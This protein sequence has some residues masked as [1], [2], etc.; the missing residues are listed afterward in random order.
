[1][2]TGKLS[3]G[4]A[5]GLSVIAAFSLTML[6]AC[7]TEGPAD[8][9]RDG[10]RALMSLDGTEGRSYLNLDDSE[11]S[12]YLK[13]SVADAKDGRW[14]NPGLSTSLAAIGGTADGR[15]LRIVSASANGVSLVQKGES[16]NILVQ[17]APSQQI[18]PGNNANWNVVM[19][20]DVQFNGGI[21]VPILPRILNLGEYTAHNKQ[22]GLNIQWQPGDDPGAEVTVTITVDPVLTREEGGDP[23]QITRER[24]MVYTTTCSDN[25]QVQ[26]PAAELSHL[27]SNV[28]VRVSLATFNYRT[29]LRSDGAR[30]GL[31]A[32][33][34]FTVPIM[35]TSSSD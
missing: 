20:Q 34:Q 5:R 24:E 4:M 1:M 22:Q 26:I 19:D 33:S 10:K 3:A 15:P 6:A 13:V 12:G 8:V 29:L 14:R 21:K 16:S 30:F 17:D 18:V 7:D 35:L 9:I 25:G 31:L 11:V 2:N 27:P 28:I 23:T 32:T